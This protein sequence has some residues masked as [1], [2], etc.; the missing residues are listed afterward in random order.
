MT[1]PVVEADRDLGLQGHYAGVATRFGAFVIDV[2]V[3]STSFAVGGLVV[4]Y[5]VSALIGNEVDLS[6]APV[7][8]TVLLGGW[9]FLY[10]VY[11]LSVAGRTPG[12][13]ALGLQVVHSDGSQLDVGHAVLRVVTFPLSFLLFGFGFLLILVRRDRRALH[14]LLGGACVVYAWDA[15]AARLRF[16]AR[17]A[18]VGPDP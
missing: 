2:T 7:V 14:D 13:A 12:M 17:S 18:P 11:A 16:L 3:V 9:W 6:D 1:G 8:S 10:C 4:E 5:V 15:R